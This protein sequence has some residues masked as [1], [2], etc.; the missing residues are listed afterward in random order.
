MTIVEA[1]EV[2]LEALG[3]VM[4]GAGEHLCRV[5]VS[6]LKDVVAAVAASDRRLV[7]EGMSE[8]GDVLFS[9]IEAYVPPTADT[10]ENLPPQCSF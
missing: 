7:I 9:V 3:V 2:D 10:A 4:P 5:D 1:T 6:R 8:P